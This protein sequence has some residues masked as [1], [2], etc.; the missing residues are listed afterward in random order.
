M[1]LKRIFL[2]S[3]YLFCAI[4]TIAQTATLSGKVTDQKGKPIESV[5]VG[6]EGSTMGTNTDAEGKYQIQLPAEQEM[7]VV[8][9]EPGYV[10]KKQTIKLQP[11]EIAYINIQLEKTK[12]LRRVTVKG[13]R[14]GSD[15]IK[16]KPNDSKLM[17]GVDGGLDRIMTMIK[18]Y[19]GTNNELTSQYNVRGGNYDENL[20]YVND[21][22][23]Y[24]PFLTRSGQQE[25][26]S[27]VNADLAENVN[28]SVGGFQ[29]KYG[30]KMSSVLDV[31]YKHP[32]EFGGR[33]VASLLG[34]SLALEGASKNQK[35]TY[36]I[37]LRQKSNQYLLKSQPTKGVYTPS[38]TDA[39]ALINYRFNDKWE[40]EAI[41]NYARNRFRFIPEEQTSSFGVINK[42]Y[43]L[44]VF[45]DGAEI[46]QFDSRFGGLSTTF[47]PNERL[48]L[49]LLVSGFQTNEK[50]TYDISG[51][52]LLG[53]L[54]T[55][56]GKE[57]FGQIKTYLGTGII[58]NYARNYLQVNV[59]NV[60]HRGSYDAGL[61]FIQWGV[62]A[63][64]TTINDKLFE[65][66]RR[67]SAGF[68]QPYNPNNL[69]LTHFY[70]SNGNF[71]YMRYSGFLQD[72]FR[73]ND[74]SG[75]TMSVGLRY[76]YSTLNNE[77]LFSPRAQI[78]Y[79]PKSWVS[80]VVFK[81]SGGLYQQ[82][83]FYRE[84]RDLNG[85][86][87]YSLMAQK[88]YHVVLG[89]DYNFKALDR[90]FKLTTSVYYK[91]LWDIVPY[92]YDNVRIRY[93]GKND[94]K[95]YAYGGE[96]R[97]YGDIVKDATSWISIG[98]LKTMENLS[99]DKVSYKSVSGADSGTFYPGYIP[100]PTDQRFMLGM[101]FEDYFP[102]WKNYKMHLNL[103]YASGL[104]FGPPDN[105]RYGD[106]LRLPDYKRVDI[107]F[108]A[109]L[110]NG[111]KHPRSKV[112]SSIKNTWLSFEVFNL[113]GIRNTLSYTWI[114]DQT[115]GKTYAVPN[116]LTSRLI[117]VKLVV[118]F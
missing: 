41:G 1:L 112:W 34:A 17:A 86:I 40:I 28:F 97:I 32:K 98:L 57:N 95:G 94:A 37:G 65:W 106:T 62:D 54:E 84:M 59:G 31:T 100:R 52:Y 25:G 107:G 24:R 35:L 30:D 117:N 90:P 71:N 8:F 116:R 77:W 72:N 105:N 91:G 70:H 104:P 114:Q 15:V 92:E 115:S 118:D 87:N 38:F 12:E 76:N 60:A 88:S 39:Q 50:E 46:D 53:E 29:A 85:N 103:M 48:K 96:V 81:L 58:H 78:S 23:I 5:M 79:K 113:L 27:F 33:V 55:D 19:V 56:L 64:Y 111:A 6:V 51:E 99:D 42:A 74:S 20:I 49:K 93:Y 44:R 9:S 108:S 102:K 89:V 101:Y 110:L 82:P 80:D 36:L 13:D 10:V 3:I 11:K 14:T 18:T 73:F 22:E 21:F 63:N 83:P 4:N 2:F 61:H 43:Q 47:K 67:D 26:M 75:L 7:L 69:E 68:T 45:Y 16:L 109:L 66:E